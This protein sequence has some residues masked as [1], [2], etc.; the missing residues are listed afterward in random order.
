MIM[1]RLVDRCKCPGRKRFGFFSAAPPFCLSVFGRVPDLLRRQP[2]R[3]T[4]GREAP[5]RRTTRPS[6]SSA[7][8]RLFQAGGRGDVPVDGLELREVLPSD[9]ETIERIGRLRVRAWRTEIAEAAGMETWL[10]EFEPV[11]R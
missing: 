11:A 8:A 10:D 5:C 9:R 6:N 3:C 4:P 7:V 1:D 2:P